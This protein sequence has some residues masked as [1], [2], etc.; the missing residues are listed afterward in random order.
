MSTL[1]P[2]PDGAR[3]EALRYQRGRDFARANDAFDEAMA[4]Y[5]S[6]GRLGD[7]VVL[8]GDLVAHYNA[9][10]D[11]KRAFEQERRA[12]KLDEGVQGLDAA[13][14]ADDLGDGE[15]VVVE[16]QR[17]HACFV[18]SGYRDAMAITEA[19]LTDLAAPLVN[20]TLVD[21]GTDEGSAARA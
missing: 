11:W 15:L 10:H 8:A 12:W 19:A 2:D 7:A 1:D 13:A 6:T 4:G 16:L 21:E 17:A 5:L 20:L 14:V 3:A 9:Q 18:E